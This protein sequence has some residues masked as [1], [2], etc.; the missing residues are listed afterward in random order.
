MRR[1]DPSIDRFGFIR[2]PPDSSTRAPAITASIIEECGF[3]VEQ[4][5]ESVSAAA[6]DPS[7]P[8]NARRLLTWIRGRG[9]TLLGLGWRLDS[10]RG[11]A[12][13]DR[14]LAFLE[15]SDLH[16][17]YGGPIR[18]VFF[19]GLPRTCKV[20]RER[21]PDISGLIDG[22]EELGELLD[23]FGIP[24]ELY[25][26]ATLRS[27]AYD[28][29]RIA[30]GNDLLRR[31]DIGKVAN[32]DRR[33]SPRF[34]MR[35]DSLVFRLLH[36]DKLG[37]PPLIRADSDLNPS[38]RSESLDLFF[39]AFRGL[40][41]D[42]LLDVLSFDSSQLIYSESKEGI[43][44]KGNETTWVEGLA[45]TWEATRPLLLTAS[46]LA[47]RAALSASLYEAGM[48]N[49]CHESC[50]WWRSSLDGEGPLDV[51]ENL[52]DQFDA[53]RAVARAGKPVQ[54]DLSRPFAAVGTDDAGIV[55]AGYLAARAAKESGIKLFILEVTL[56]TPRWAWGL[57]DLAKARALLALVRNLEDGTFRVAMQAEM[58]RDTLSLDP[59]RARVQLAARVAL[60]DDIEPDNGRSPSIVRIGTRS[61]TSMSSESSTLEES[62]RV[63][64][65]A[66]EEWRRLRAIGAVPDMGRD[67][68][69][70]ERTRKLLADARAL[71]AGMEAAIPDLYS[72]KGFLQAL[73]AGFFPLP[74]LPR[75]PE[76]YPS[77]TSVRT[78]FSNGGIIA[79][80]GDYSPLGVMERVAK[81]NEALLRLRSGS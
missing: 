46:P 14:L 67:A 65:M 28:E 33:G 20:V 22:E 27:V 71:I 1:A 58:S 79:V 81:A 80:A 34:G 72:P 15:R 23:T 66:L 32:V 42:G 24:R 77:A 40:G 49:A 53:L 75:R 74:W 68:E 45:A 21:H 61:G 56:K 78:A 35:G 5:D 26:T 59:G 52:E 36:G 37:L 17:R 57:Q 25:P 16:A 62:V 7:S 30:F 29:L 41:A 64:R 4:A 19:A 11:I 55:A 13:L 48:G 70:R 10:D 9:I 31:G 38:D 73:Y 63:T 43:A 8:E 12:L 50:F 47:G 44:D 69:P 51:S 39:A 76:Q 6:V 3:A 54:A 2:L 60:M 18:E